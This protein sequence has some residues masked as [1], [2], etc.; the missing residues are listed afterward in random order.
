MSFFKNIFNKGK[1]NPAEQEDSFNK[2]LQEIDKVKYQNE[3]HDSVFIKPETAFDII[4][5]IN[6]FEHEKLNIYVD[7]FGERWVRT[8]YGFEPVIIYNT[9]FENNQL[10][11]EIKARENEISNLNLRN[12]RM[13]KVLEHEQA[14]NINYRE[15]I[16]KQN[17]LAFFRLIR[18]KEAKKIRKN[19]TLLNKTILNNITKIPDEQ[20]SQNNTDITQALIKVSKINEHLKQ[21]LKDVYSENEKILASISSNNNDTHNI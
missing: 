18:S 16:N 17:S 7:E 10:K 13:R 15:K 1:D 20:K 4:A 8:K 21:I 3:F 19:I 12:E 5:L 6:K 9:K 2:I 14:L 11:L